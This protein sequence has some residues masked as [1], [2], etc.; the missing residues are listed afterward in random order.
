VDTPWDDR[1]PSVTCLRDGT[2]VLNWFTYYGD[3]QESQPGK[4]T[5]FKEL[6]LAF[7]KDHGLTWSEPRLVPVTE[8]HVWGASS[9]IVELADGALLWPVYREF[10]NPL[11]V[12]SAMLRSTDGGQTWT[13][14]H[15]VDQAYPDNDEPAVLELPDGR[16]L[17][18]MRNN[19]GD[20]MWWSES[21]DGGLTWSPS[22]RTGFPGHAPYLLRTG[23]G[24]LLMGHRLPGTS[25][26]WSL[27]DGRTW[28]GSLQ[29]DACIGAYPSLVPLRDG[30]I[31]CVYY[32][33]G[34]GSSIRGQRLQAA[35][36]GVTGLPWARP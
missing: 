22:A 13:G 34:D 1:D 11:R 5:H 30:S 33:E 18:L 28:A 8:D 6:W 10:Q 14:P 36:A 31:L 24:V 15:W 29:L 20:S 21:K 35:R 7:S 9:P 23:D 19:G 4:P 26:H 25:L 3:Y 2:L 16:V 17:C 27:D 12:W 32:E